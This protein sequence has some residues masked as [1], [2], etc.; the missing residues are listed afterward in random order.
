MSLK[1]LQIWHMLTDQL[2]NFF[3][4]CPLCFSVKKEWLRLCFLTQD[5]T[6]HN[7]FLKCCNTNE[8]IVNINHY[9]TDL[10]ESSFLVLKLAHFLEIFLKI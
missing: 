2:L 7:H 4:I 3:Q 6:V 8:P 10:K 5:L 9:E 1:Y